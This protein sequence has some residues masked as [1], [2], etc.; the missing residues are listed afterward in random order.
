MDGRKVLREQVV[1]GDSTLRREFVEIFLVLT[2]DTVGVVLDE[3]RK[4]AH[5]P[6]RKQNRQ[7]DPL[8]M[9]FAHL[10]TCLGRDVGHTLLSQTSDTGHIV[11]G[12]ARWRAAY[13]GSV[14]ESASIAT[15]P[16]Y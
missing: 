4:C 12:Y 9:R 7:N 13:H 3:H 15:S 2:V 8:D 11:S 1:H 16:P 10:V 6:N 14:C 5:D